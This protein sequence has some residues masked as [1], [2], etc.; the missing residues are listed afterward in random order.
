MKYTLGKA[1]VGAA[2]AVGLT[3][4]TTMAKAEDAVFKF[5]GV[6][7]LSGP[8]SFLGLFEEAAVRLAVEQFMKG[9]CIVEAIPAQ[10]CEGG[11]LKIGG[12]KIPIEWKAY[13]DVSED[14]KSI[15]AVTRLVE[16]D[17][18]RAIWGPR[19]NSALLSAST[20]LDPQKIISIC[21][22][23]SSPAMT[24]GRKYGHDITDTG[25]IEKH[26]IAAFISE[27]PEK[28]KEHGVDPKVF[29]GRKKAAFIGR[30][31]LYTVHGSI[32]FQEGI[33]KGGKKYAYDHKD[34]V[35]Y[36]FGTT[37]FAPYV[38]KI[39]EQKPDIVMMDAYVIP[40]MLAIM[41]EMKKQGL[42]FETGKVVLLGNDVL[43][44]Q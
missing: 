20:I 4:G 15:D 9:D 3:A 39:A 6:F 12:K 13:D 11:G 36:P 28:L 34:A 10:P 40:D 17:G 42:D 43:M 26:A 1:L 35:F 37:D 16:Q 7:T 29:E 8:A 21:A 22:I 18:A 25:V 33:E 31:E 44:L 14:K 24:V 23:C 19:M 32:G 38:A 2:L 27:S 30:N 5:G 41:A